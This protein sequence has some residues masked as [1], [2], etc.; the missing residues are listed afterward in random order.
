MSQRGAS[1]YSYFPWPVLPSWMMLP[2]Y[3]RSAVTTAN[4][5]QTKFEDMC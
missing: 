5:T 3:H 4:G 2:T 1:I